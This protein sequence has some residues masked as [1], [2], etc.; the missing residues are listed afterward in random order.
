MKYR[1][2]GNVMPAVEMLLDR[3]EKVYTQKGG[4]CW[5]SDGID[6]MPPHTRDFSHE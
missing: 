4:M 6:G 3:G 1:I 2:V 5:M